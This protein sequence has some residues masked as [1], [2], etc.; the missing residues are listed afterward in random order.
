MNKRYFWIGA[1]TLTALAMLV[2]TALLTNPTLA[3]RP[4]HPLAPLVEEVTPPPPPNNYLI[5]LPVVQPAPDEIP[6]N[7]TLE[8]AADYAR[9]LTYRQAQPILAE[10]ERLR[11]EGKITGFEV[12]PNLHGVAVEVSDPVVL[13]EFSRLQ[14]VAAVS[15]LKDEPPVC[16]AAAAQALPEQV[17]GL[18]RM[19]AEAT[20]RLQATG[21]GVQATDPSIDV[22]ASP[23]NDWTSVSGQTTPNIA[24]TMRILRGGRVIATESTTSYSD[25]Y[26]YFY[27]NWHQ[28]PTYGYDWTLQS[29]DVVEVT[30]HGSTVSTVV[31]NLSAWVDPGADTVTGI[32]DP[33]RSI[34]M[35]LYAYSS[36]PCRSTGYNQTASVDGSGNFSAD[37]TS[38][39]DFDRRAWSSIYTRDANGNSTNASFYAYRISGYFDNTSFYGYLKPEVNFTATLD[40]A[41]NTV[42]TYSDRSSANGYYYGYFTQTIQSGDVIQVSGGGISMQ[43]TATGLDVSLDPATDQATG[44]TGANRLVKAHFY[45]RTWGYVQT[46]CSWGSDCNGIVADG[47]GAFVL[48]TT[49]DLVRGDYA[50]FY[51]YDAE[52]NYQYAYDRPI[53]AIVANLDWSSVRGYWGDPGAG[54]VTIILKDSGGAVKETDSSVWVSSW[55]GQFYAYMSGIIPTDIIEVTDGVVTETMTVQNLTTRLHGNTGHLA[56]SAYN[57]HL[58]AQLYDF[59]RDSGYQ[60]GYCSETDVTG[61]V[62]DLTFS[63]VDVGGQDSAEVWNTGPDGHYTYRYP[64]AFTVNAEKGDDY[65]NGYSE[66]PDV[67]VTVTLQRGGSPIAVYTTTS[68]SSGYYYAHLSGG[69][70]VT[71][72]QGDTVQVQ[73][74]DGDNVSLPI[75]ELTVNVDPVNNR[76]YGKSLASEPVKPQVRR[77]YNYGYYSYSQNTTADVSGDYSASFDGLYWSRDCSAVQVGGHCTQPAVY[78]YNTAGHSVWVEKPQPPSVSAD[79]YESDDTSATATA[80]AGVQSH[81]FHVDTDTDWVKFTV[82]AEDI[83][84]WCVRISRTSPTTSPTASRPST[85]GGTWR[86]GCIFITPTARLS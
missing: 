4:S 42:S 69:T 59:R 85:W 67:P 36:D 33:G 17:L 86:R 64:S 38:Q 72:T 3:A 55:D 6:S 61:G 58:L 80:Y 20:S 75:P 76:L 34:E 44:T 37:F 45:K 9:S 39:V 30:A 40:R 1:V 49:L 2:T 5:A 13:E 66:T 31:A 26:Y 51:V 77:R 23:G 8:Q 81:T 22:Y 11:A 54:Y 82:S 27:P 12:R 7:L 52:G 68:Q 57:N 35:W 74:D 60:Y 48:T 19:V 28:C 53:P 63:G 14:D 15:P 29:G 56:G 62:Y 84:G 24:V 79:I 47:S 70:P 43:Y 71:I 21:L 16:A 41:G 65:V 83:T 78:Y 73:T 10:L 18:S 50:Y 25:G 46:S 32:T